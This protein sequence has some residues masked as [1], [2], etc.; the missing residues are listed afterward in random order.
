MHQRTARHQHA[1]AT[2]CFDVR[3]VFGDIFRRDQIRC[4][5]GAG[6][7]GEP[8]I[9]V[10]P[11]HAFRHAGRAAGIQENHVVAGTRDVERRAVADLR[12][13]VERHGEFDRRRAVADL[14]PERDLRQPI[15][16]RG[17]VRRELGAVHDDLAVGVVE[18]V[19]QLVRDV[20]VVDV[21]RRQPR[22]EARAE[23]LEVRRTVAHV[24]RDLVARLR[25]TIEETAREIVGAAVEVAPRD[26]FAVVNQTRPLRGHDGADGVEDVAIV[27]RHDQLPT[28]SPTGTPSTI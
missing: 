1:P 6:R 26:E 11:H 27:P 12:E 14:D 7:A 8:V 3:R 24:E 22:L 18:D 20:A 23:R 15:A 25:V 5:R 28:L 4:R 17:D 16:Q 2:G 21:D 9:I 10:R 13:V 19:P